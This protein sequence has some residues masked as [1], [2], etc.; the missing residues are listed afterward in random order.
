MMNTY[1]GER[2]CKNQNEA[3]SHRKAVR[4]ERWHTISKMGHVDHFHKDSHDIFKATTTA[5]T[6]QFIN[7]FKFPKSAN[8]SNLTG[9]TLY[10]I[11]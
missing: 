8:W 4:G 2:A 10:G 9:N 7:M 1:I 5:Q 6:C 11:L 3:M